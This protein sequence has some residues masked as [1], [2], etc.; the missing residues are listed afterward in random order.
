MPKPGPNTSSHRRVPRVLVR[1]F[2]AKKLEESITLLVEVL[3]EDFVVVEDGDQRHPKPTPSLTPP[4]ADGSTTVSC[5]FL[6]SFSSFF[7]WGGCPFFQSCLYTFAVPMCVIHVHD[8]SAH[9]TA[10]HGRCKP[11]RLPCGVHT[12]TNAKK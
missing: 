4:N 5:I 2:I 9:G 3:E 11:T 1:N 10:S 8:T 6:F 7:L 12:N